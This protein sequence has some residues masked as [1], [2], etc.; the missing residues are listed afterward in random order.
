MDGA[1][2]YCKE[3]S[4]SL[5]QKTWKAGCV[6]H[7]HMGILSPVNTLIHPGTQFLS[8]TFSPRWTCTLEL[9]HLDATWWKQCSWNVGWDGSEPH[10]QTFFLVGTDKS[11]LY[12]LPA[13]LGPQ[14]RMFIDVLVR[15]GCLMDAGNFS[16]CQCLENEARTWGINIVNDLLTGKEISHSLSDLNRHQVH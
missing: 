4:L 5:E 3:H 15:E 8:S 11:P 7:S 6:V 9:F 2:R 16:R 13:S 10:S 1:I 12:G 14:A